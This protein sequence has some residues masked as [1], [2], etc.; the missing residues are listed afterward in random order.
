MQSIRVAALAGLALLV[1]NA[2]PREARAQANAAGPIDDAAAIEHRLALGEAEP[3]A[4]GGQ[5]PARLM[6]V[7]ARIT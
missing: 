4:V 5:L 6:V 2:L 3:D 1:L 7:D